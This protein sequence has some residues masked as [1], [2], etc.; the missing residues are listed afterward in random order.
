MSLKPHWPRI[1]LLLVLSGALLGWIS[2]RSEILFAD[3][4][5]YIHQ[6][7]RLDQGAWSDGLLRAVDH[8]AYPLAIVAAHR[9][10][11]G[12]S[13]DAWQAAAQGASLVAGVL[14]VVPLYLVSLELFGAS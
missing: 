12:E 13:P 7:Q 9:V 2:A 11:G 4:L 1:G 14:L 3:G 10:L 6:A 8:P 5:R